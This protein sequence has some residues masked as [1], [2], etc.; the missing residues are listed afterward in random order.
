MQDHVTKPVVDRAVYDEQ[1]ATFGDA[2][3]VYFLSL[4]TEELARRSVALEEAARL[5]DRGELGRTA[6]AIASAAGNL[7]FVAL[8]ILCRRLEHELGTVPADEID[9]VLDELRQ[10]IAV[11]HETVGALCAEIAADAEAAVAP[12]AP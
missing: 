10:A 2:R 12:P 4:L 8:M 5:D 6:H 1:R 11:A 7:G 9:A 3:I